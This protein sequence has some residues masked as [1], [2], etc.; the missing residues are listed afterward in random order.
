[1]QRFEVQAKGFADLRP[2]R[3]QSASLQRIQ[4]AALVFAAHPA[5]RLADHAEHVTP[6]GRQ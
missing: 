4:A 1:M 3:P 6:A 2:S 5:R